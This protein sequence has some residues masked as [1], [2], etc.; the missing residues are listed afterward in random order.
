MEELFRSTF[1]NTAYYNAQPD[2]FLINNGN[3]L[4]YTGAAPE[5][6]VIEI[7]ES[8]E[9]IAGHA[10]EGV[11]ASKIVMH[12]GVK[13]LGFYA[14]LESSVVEVVLPDNLTVLPTGTFSRTQNLKTIALPDTLTEIGFNAFRYSGLTEID[15]PPKVQTLGS[16]CFAGCNGLTKVTIPASVTTM[17]GACFA[18]CSGLTEV[19]IPASVKI[20]DGACFS[21]CINLTSITF[22]GTMAEWNAIE[23]MDSWNSMVPATEVVCSDGSVAL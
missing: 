8:V 12:N 5:S 4:R 23:K 14:F 11:N 10:F 15:W 21:N 6:G 13:L 2:G 18:S 1:K 17:N 22:Q 16:G 7:P 19:T 9:G 20:M 3:L